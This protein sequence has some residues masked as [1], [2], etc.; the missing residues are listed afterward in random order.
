MG[1]FA[2]FERLDGKVVGDYKRTSFQGLRRRLDHFATKLRDGVDDGEV[3]FFFLIS[4][5]SQPTLH[6]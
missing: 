1:H 3:V 4:G 2:K 5:F 6:V